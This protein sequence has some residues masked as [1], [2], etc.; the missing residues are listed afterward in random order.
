MK[1][2]IRWFQ[3]LKGGY[4]HGT[5]LKWKVENDIVMEQSKEQGNHLNHMS[6]YKGSYNKGIPHLGI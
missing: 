2:P 1:D 6:W 4:V 5:S 3:P